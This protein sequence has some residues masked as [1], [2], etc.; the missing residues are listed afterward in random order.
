MTAGIGS[1][2]LA[3]FSKKKNHLDLNN[4][5]IQ[6]KICHRVLHFSSFMVIAHILRKKT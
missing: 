4:K 5:V 3:S 1:S 2:R 6:K